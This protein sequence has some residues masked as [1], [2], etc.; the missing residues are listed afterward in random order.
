MS[1][2]I[3]KRQS[4]KWLSFLNS[5]LFPASIHCNEY[6][7]HKVYYKKVKTEGINPEE[8]YR[9]WVRPKKKRLRRRRPDFLT[10]LPHSLTNLLN[11][12]TTAESE[13]ANDFLCNG[14]ISQREAGCANGL[15]DQAHTQGFF[16]LGGEKPWEL[17]CWMSQYDKRKT[18]TRIK[19]VCCII[20]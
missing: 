13:Q 9:S 14:Y 16:S 15:N 12:C 7:T 4:D 5:I 11:N 10:S 1:C 3:Q 19:R 17:D 6:Y 20:R 8:N 2:I 18:R